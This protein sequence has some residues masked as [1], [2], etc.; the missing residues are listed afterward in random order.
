MVTTSS[1]I[2][3]SLAYSLLDLSPCDD[4]VDL[5]VPQLRW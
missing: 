5:G 2:G 3:F 1:T 4:D